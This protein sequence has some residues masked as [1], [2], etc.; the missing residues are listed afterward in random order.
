MKRLQVERRRMRMGSLNAI[1][2]SCGT[3]TIYLTGM[4]VQRWLAVPTEMHPVPFPF[5]QLLCTRPF[6]N[7]NAGKNRME[8]HSNTDPVFASRS[9]RGVAGGWDESAS[10][11][12]DE[13]ERSQDAGPC[14]DA[15]VR[16]KHQLAVKLTTNI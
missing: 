3:V 6:T 7:W 1:V 16:S 15:S 14:E 8:N 9:K 5:C 2:F 4:G 12:R 13:R 11:C 10:S